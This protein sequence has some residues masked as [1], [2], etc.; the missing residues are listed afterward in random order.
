MIAAQRPSERPSF[1]PRWALYAAIL[2]S[3]MGLLDGT[4]TNVVLPLVQREL[5]ADS[6]AL[7]WVVLGYTLFLSA[8]MLIG[9]ALGDR[10]GRKKM[11]EVGV[12]IFTLSSVA[13]A[14]AQDA[15]FLV[16]ARCIQGIGGALM[17]PESLALIS[18]AYPP[19]KRGG[20][21]GTWSAAIALAAAVGP[22]L[23]GWL[24]QVF[25]W[26]A[27]FYM[28]VPLAVAS[29][30]ILRLRVSES[31]NPE[32]RHL[33]IV[34]ATCVTVALGFATWGL[35]RIP[36]HGVDL[37][38]LL[39]IV[40]GLVLLVVFFFIEERSPEPMVPMRLFRSRQFTVANIYTLVMYGAIGAVMFFLPFDLI[41]VRGY[42]PSAVGAAML[43]LI[44]IMTLFSTLA[45]RLAQ[46]IGYRIPLVAGAVIAGAGFALVGLS[47]PHASYWAGLF[48][49]FV[50]MGIGMTTFVAP[51]T[52]AVMTSV[53]ADNVGAA[54]GINNAV[55]R[56]AG[57]AAIAVGSIL[58]VFAGARAY[59]HDAP[60]NALVTAQFPAGADAAATAHLHAA[61]SVAYTDTMV[62]CGIAACISAALALLLA[63][64]TSV[65]E[66]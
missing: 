45:G 47:N 23:G 44:V 60:R 56:A 52:T 11:L 19:D 55:A 50:L 54:S 49:A 10:F 46:R 38:S 6:T 18:V 39:S 63:P 33:D 26:R 4:A 20:A 14:L 30:L 58:I 28:N 59:G 31:H 51:L 1:E 61:F 7:Q 64:G 16:A 25:S 32:S 21:I 57:L 40:A 42:A 48:P 34:G 12:V 13:C 37:E 2:C 3:G 9:G 65:A 41:N 22:I 35:D 36:Q 43:P 62:A 66:A 8:L 27:I 29:L 53:D 24:A 17:V 15:V 5:H